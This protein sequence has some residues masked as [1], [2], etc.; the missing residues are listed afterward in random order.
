MSLPADLHSYLDGEIGIDDLSIELRQAARTWERRFR[1][2]DRAYASSAPANLQLDIMRAVHQ[3]ARRRGLATSLGWLLRPRTFALSPLVAAVAIL[4]LV[5]AGLRLRQPAAPATSAASLIYVQLSVNVP[6]ARS[7]AVAGDFSDW[8]P[9]AVLD[10][11]DGDG[12]WTGRIAVAPGVHE[13]MFVIDNTRWMTDP[14]ATRYADDD[15]GHRNAV[16][17][18]AAPAAHT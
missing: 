18:V 10:D 12:V 7:V 2:F 1:E 16:L 8:R 11:P 3:L 13:Y 9:I 6:A 17:A 14:R 4:L 5:L 15:F